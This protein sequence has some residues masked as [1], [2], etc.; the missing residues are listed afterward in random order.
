MEDYYKILGVS[1]TASKDEIK[2][3]YRKLAHKHHP[4]KGGDEKTFKKISEAY[5]TLSDDNKRAQYDTWG[6]SGSGMGGQTG[7]RPGGGFGF[8][9]K[10]GAGFDF[11][12]GD[13]F[14]EFFSFG[15]R[16]GGRRRGRGGRERGEDIKIKITVALS[17]VIK[18]NE[19]TVH[20][21]KMNSCTECKGSGDAPGAKKEDCK[22]C[23]GQG[24]V[25]TSIGPFTQ[26]VICPE[27]QGEGKISDKKCSSCKGEGRKETKEEI[28]FTVPAGIDSGQVIR[29]EG[30]GNAGRKGNPP[31]DLLVEIT[32]RNDTKFKRQGADLYY[33]AD[34][35]YTQL[36][37]GGEIDITLLSG[38]SISVKIPAGTSPETIFRISGKG[39]PY[40]SS[41]STGNLYVKAKVHV[42]KKANKK[43][44]EILQK[45]QEEGL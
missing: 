3:A 43:Q 41:Y 10:S 32:V 30:K 42:P 26:V 5:H 39:L 2:K 17:E 21:S 45:L 9:N 29:V 8:D 25:R 7:S 13:I 38:K 31:G 11:D 18:N 4:D 15:Q 44:K 20:V 24:K 36:L 35:K 33:D 23:Q 40:L 22:T 6:K 19:R 37:L 12:F 1:K 14:E 16:G 34:L 28:K 27:C